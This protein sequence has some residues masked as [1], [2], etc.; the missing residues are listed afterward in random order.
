MNQEIIEDVELK[1]EIEEFVYDVWSECGADLIASVGGDYDEGV[2]AVK[3]LAFN[4]LFSEYGSELIEAIRGT[5]DD[6]L[7]NFK[8]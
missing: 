2:E 6:V 1:L 3:D 8:G 7:E 5:V 4:R